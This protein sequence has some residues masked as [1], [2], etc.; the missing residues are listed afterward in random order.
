MSFFAIAFL[1]QF[2]KPVSI[3]TRLASSTAVVCGKTRGSFEKRPGFRRRRLVAP[4][5]TLR[6]LDPFETPT[7]AKL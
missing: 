5:S 2:S 1:K 6:L 3:L 4:A 7:D